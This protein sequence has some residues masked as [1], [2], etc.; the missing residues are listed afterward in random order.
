MAVSLADLVEAGRA[1][2]VTQEC[3]NGVI[4]EQ[5][6]FPALAEIARREMI[7]NAARLAKAARA[8][9]VPVVHCLALRRPDGLGSSTNA[10]IFGAAKKSPVTLAPGSDAARVVDEIGVEDS[11]IVLTRYHGVGPMSGTDLD[12]VLR[13]LGVTTIVGIGVSVNVGMTNFTMDAVNLGYQFVFPRDAVAGVPEDYANA[14]IDN[15]LSL[16]ATVVT[17]EELIGA[18]SR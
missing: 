11:D 10:R 12:S 15:T 6:V 7:P 16:L 2:L 3:Q 8:A 18:W 5:A 17:T 4:G 13:N 14:L 9:G 1:A